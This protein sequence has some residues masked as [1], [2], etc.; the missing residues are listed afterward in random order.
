[1][2]TAIATRPLSVLVVDHDGG[3]RHATRLALETRRVAVSEAADGLQALRAVAEA[4]YDALLVAA[5]LPL[6]RELDL[7]RRLRAAQAAVQIALIA[8]ASSPE[9]RV[10]GLEAGADDFVG[11]CCTCGAR[12]WAGS[13]SASPSGTCRA[14][15]RPA[16]RR[17]SS[18][19]SATSATCCARG[20]RCLARLLPGRPY[21]RA[22][23][24]PAA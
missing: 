15:S 5:G 13:R 24:S 3:R 2:P 22:Q 17:G 18:I 9:Q 1:M 11:S 8:D 23:W 14:S 7:C 21:V 20:S 6:L 19:R 12:T 16:A 10:A 4:E